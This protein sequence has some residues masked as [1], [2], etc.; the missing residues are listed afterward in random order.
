MRSKYKQGDLSE[1]RPVQQN[2]RG[3]AVSGKTGVLA[4]RAVDAHLRTKSRVLLLTF[5]I[6]LRNWIHD[7]IDDVREDFGWS[8]S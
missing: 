4:W 3:V 7:A 2:I 8:N 1:S 6:T 5:Y